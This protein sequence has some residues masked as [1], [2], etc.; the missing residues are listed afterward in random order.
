MAKNCIDCGKELPHIAAYCYYCGNRQ[1]KTEEVSDEKKLQQALTD[2][3]KEIER[4]NKSL[5]LALKYI[6]EGTSEKLIAKETEI[7]QK[8]Q[9]LKEMELKI[10]ETNSE[11]SE[12]EKLLEGKERELITEK[13]NYAQTKHDLA[14]SIAESKKL[15]ENCKTLIKKYKALRQQL[16]AT[17]TIKKLVENQIKTNEDFTNHMK[18]LI[19]PYHRETENEYKNQISEYAGLLK[20][21]R[22]KTKIGLWVFCSIITIL[23]IGS[24]ILIYSRNHILSEKEWLISENEQT[25][26]N[27]KNQ[28]AKIIQEKD[29]IAKE[30]AKLK[31][32]IDLIPLYPIFIKSLKVGNALSDGEEETEPGNKLYSA[33]SMFLVPQIEYLGIRQKTTI[34][35]YL[36]LYKNGE[37]RYDETSPKGYTYSYDME[38]LPQGKIKLNGWG[39][40]TEGYWSVGNYRYEI[41]YD[42]MCLA[43]V[44]FKIY[45]E[46]EKNTDK[47]AQE[48]LQLQKEGDA[49]GN[50]GDE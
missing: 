20:Q 8:D 23:L 48:I 1:V 38:V 34:K 32:E 11:L 7:L 47:P 44:D 4:L 13:E 50:R 39:S 5:D 37:L 31:D 46:T 41:W 33:T 36:K 43:G 35:L 42:D 15:K 10:A 29:T 3:E 16:L 17:G 30:N 22:T 21:L 40:E 45:S 49:G 28:L 18:D 19:L 25:T 27:Y 6:D 9:A 2:A 14:K 12:T 24:G 26:V